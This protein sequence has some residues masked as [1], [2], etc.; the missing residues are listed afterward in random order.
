MAN[1]GGPAP[2]FI[3]LEFKRVSGLDAS[4]VSSFAKMKQLAQ[5]HAFTL[6][7]T[8]LSPTMQHQ[9]APALFQGEAED[10]WRTFPDLDHAVEWCEEQLL[11]EQDEAGEGVTGALPDSTAE[12]G[13]L[14]A[15]MEPRTVEAGEYL[16]RQG[17]RPGGLYFLHTGRL[18]AQLEYPDGRTVRLRKMQPGVFVGELS[19]YAGALA[20]ASVLADCS[21]TVFCLPATELARLEQDEP[22]VA[23]AFHKRV[24]QL[25]SER[26][27]DATQTL[28]VLMR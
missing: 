10:G 1:V 24:A 27:L 9:L 26:L 22:A 18:T 21:S 12:L 13:A 11:A 25:T 5:A 4:A 28:S 16:I 17:E 19:L 14:A 3:I 20:S 6:L 7:F 23:A 8:G 15:H 2:R